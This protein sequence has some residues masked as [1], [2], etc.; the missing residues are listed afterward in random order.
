MKLPYKYKGLVSLVLLTIVLP[1]II[2]HFALR[3][4]FNVWY[5]CRQLD[6]RIKAM[7]TDTI[8]RANFVAD[9]YD[10]VFSGELLDVVRGMTAESDVQIIG[11]EPQVNVQY[12]GLSVHTAQLILVGG[13][14]SLLRIVR[15]MEHR[16]P[17]CCLHTLE[18]R[19]VIDRQIQH[20]QL[21]LTLYVQQVVLNNS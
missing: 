15:N 3:N 9:R 16:L 1:W 11:Y 19:T 21:V 7:E 13:Y 20:K 2:W 14:V 6:S 5:D 17:R 12:D 4:T 8:H 10:L 18:W